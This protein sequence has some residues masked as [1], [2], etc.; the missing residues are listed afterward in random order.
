M[1]SILYFLSALRFTYLVSKK[2]VSLAVSFAEIAKNHSISDPYSQL[3]FEFITHTGNEGNPT[4]T[5][6][7]GDPKYE[8]MKGVVNR[9]KSV[10]VDDQVEKLKLVDYRQVLL[11]TL[12]T[13]PM[14]TEEMIFSFTA[15]YLLVRAADK[16]ESIIGKLNYKYVK[17]DETKVCMKCPTKFTLITR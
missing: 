13:F 8:L 14:L 16:Y 6:T 2:Y 1:K 17:D 5:D 15:Q 10:D 3:L 12:W 4:N 9:L 11:D 7:L